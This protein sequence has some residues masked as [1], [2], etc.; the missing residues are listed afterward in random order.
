MAEEK[1]G[2]IGRSPTDAVEKLLEEIRFRGLESP[3]SREAELAEKSA[4]ATPLEMPRL[5]RLLQ[6]AV[7]QVDSSQ[8]YQTFKLPGTQTMVHDRRGKTEEASVGKTIAEESKMST[9]ELLVQL[10]KLSATKEKN[11]ENYLADPASRLKMP[12][13]KAAEER[14]QKM[15]TRFED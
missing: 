8:V 12:E 9:E 4:E 10:G 6:Q 13:Q 5:T 15:L 2:K 14:L 11:Y 3:A 7:R 1:P